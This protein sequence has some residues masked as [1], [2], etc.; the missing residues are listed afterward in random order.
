MLP[1]A[2]NATSFGLLKLADSAGLPSPEYD[3]SP[4]PAT[5]PMSSTFDCPFDHR[6]VA[7]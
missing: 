4:F 5:V 3:G 2:S 6:P 1:S 7:F